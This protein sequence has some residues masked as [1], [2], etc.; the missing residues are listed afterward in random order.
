[1]LH[2]KLRRGAFRHDLYYKLAE[3]TV[4]VP[5]LRE[6]PDDIP[7]LAQHFLD[8]YAEAHDADDVTLSE[9]ALARLQDASW[10]GNVRELRNLIERTADLG[11]GLIEAD[12]LVASPPEEPVAS[13]P[14]ASEQ[15]GASDVPSAS[16]SDM[17]GI[18][19]GT[20]SDAIL[21]LEALKRQAVERAYRLCDGD[22]D[23]AAVELD[24]GRSTLYRMLDRYDIKD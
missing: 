9:D 22:V 8:R 17:G 15:A 18:V 24:I 7:D 14:P 1:L 12:D 10:P 21:P 5:P 20:D 4:T 6:R 23:R 16:A 19:L 2:K 11:S 3:L 13:R